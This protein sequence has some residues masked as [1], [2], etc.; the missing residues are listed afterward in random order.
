MEPIRPDGP[1]SE[2]RAAVLIRSARNPEPPP[3]M[4]ARIYRRLTSAARPGSAWR[5]RPAVAFVVVLCFI[6]AASAAALR[7]SR[8]RGADRHPPR[9]APGHAAPP[10]AKDAREVPAVLAKSAPEPAPVPSRPLRTDV[11][12]TLHREP[13]STAPL[14]ESA[15]EPEPVEPAAADPEAV[16]VVDATRALR[17]EHDPA[18]ALGLLATYRA[19]F[20]SGDLFEESLILTIEAKS[21]LDDAE[22]GSLAHEYLRRYPQGRFR[23]PAEKARLRFAH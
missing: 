20:P 16:L 10:I 21:S 23:G 15:Q 22:A 11:S 17:H 1:S 12:R 7:F 6:C 18:R 2:D 9:S 4:E 14:A 13:R 3:G 5:L 19:R 8:H